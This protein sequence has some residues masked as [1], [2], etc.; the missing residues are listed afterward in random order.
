MKKC[1]NL[2]VCCSRRR[3]PGP[4]WLAASH[5]AGIWERA[6]SR[7]A[8]QTADRN[9]KLWAGAGRQQTNRSIQRT[10]GGRRRGNKEEAHVLL[11]D[12]ALHPWI[13]KFWSKSYRIKICGD[14]CWILTKLPRKSSFGQVRLTEWLCNYDVGWMVGF[15]NV[16][17][18]IHVI[19]SGGVGTTCLK[20]WQHHMQIPS[21]VQLSI[22]HI[23]SAQRRKICDARGG[24]WKVKISGRS[25]RF[26]ITNSQK[27]SKILHQI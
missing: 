16:L 17:W 25:D 27:K 6:N 10:T 24:F 7:S 5:R 19:L 26:I 20:N 18:N 15:Q 11:E 3:R 22:S 9:K 1:W 12:K 4:P 8:G 23:D 13:Q 21:S 14:W 2:Q